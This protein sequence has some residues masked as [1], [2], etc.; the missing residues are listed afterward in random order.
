MPV[1]KRTV[2]VRL[3]GLDGELRPIGPTPHLGI[4]DEEKLGIGQVQSRQ[5]L[6]FAAISQPP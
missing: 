5:S 6:I 3:D 2:D 4:V 1:L